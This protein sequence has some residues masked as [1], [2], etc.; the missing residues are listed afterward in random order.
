[1]FSVQNEDDHLPLDRISRSI[2]ITNKLTY[3]L[4]RIQDHGVILR[5]AYSQQR[6]LMDCGDKQ[7]DIRGS[8]DLSFLA[9]FIS[10][11]FKKARKTLARRICYPKVEPQKY[12]PYDKVVIKNTADQ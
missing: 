11:S 8:V 10:S 7:M 3:D 2:K 6:S 5:R 12:R 1:M 4:I 9:P